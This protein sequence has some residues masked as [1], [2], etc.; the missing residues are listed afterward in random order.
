LGSGGITYKLLTKCQV[1]AFYDD[2]DGFS[3]YMTGNFSGGSSTIRWL[4]Q[5]FYRGFN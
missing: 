3:G 5:N 4:Q 1:T 2:G